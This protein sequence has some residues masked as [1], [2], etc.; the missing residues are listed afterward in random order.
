MPRIYK[1]L[2]NFTLEFYYCIDFYVG[3]GD[4]TIALQFYL[5]YV[6]LA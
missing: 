1:L 4:T 2:G 6:V 3:K 5:L